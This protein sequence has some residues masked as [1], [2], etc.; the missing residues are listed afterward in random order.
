MQ[1][2]QISVEE[3]ERQRDQ[4]IVV[5]VRSHI[6]YLEGAVLDSVNIPLF[7]EE[8]RAKI[9][10][11]FKKSPRAARFV[12][13]D[14][15]GPKL[16]KFIRRIYGVS[17]GKPLVILCWRGGMRSRAT[18]DLLHMAGIEALQLGGGYKRYRQYVNQELTHF[19]LDCKLIVIKGKSGTGKTEILSQLAQQGQPVLDLEALAAHR[20]S[21]FGRWEET[22]ASTQKNFDTRLLAK[23]E[24][25]QHAKY[26]LVEGESKRIGNIYLPNFLF[27]KM[28]TAAII[29][30][31]CSMPERIARIVR[32]YAPMSHQA[33]LTMYRA[34][35]RL[36]HKLGKA[37]LYAL[38]QCLDDEDYS[39]FVDLVLSR[40][41]DNIYDHQLP[42]KSVLAV[43]NSD[44]IKKAADEIAA[45]VGE[46]S[47]SG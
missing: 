43:V 41:Y 5:D 2:G 32:D 46:I 47:G 21:A 3:L 31:D 22:H 30:V 39:T 36:K 24:Q 27:E 29:E 16:S 1:V 15:I 19:Q 14:I 34:L 40:H 44:D 33:R 42:G 8:E 18:V 20:G 12:A 26:I 17:A 6:E 7:N 23:L 28:R 9:G 35:S 25:L 45:I 37:D 11:V 4:Y 38:K 10:V 13:L